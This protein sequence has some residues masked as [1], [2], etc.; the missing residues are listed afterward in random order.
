[1]ASISTGTEGKTSIPDSCSL[2]TLKV[3][4][5][6]RRLRQ[7]PMGHGTI[8][9]RASLPHNGHTGGSWRAPEEPTSLCGEQNQT[10]MCP[11]TAEWAR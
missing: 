9:K 1:M 10:K 7:H 11:P 8:F 4:F 5:V 3:I 2:G 6:S